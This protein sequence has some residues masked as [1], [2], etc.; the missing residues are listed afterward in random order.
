[1]PTAR[2]TVRY[3]PHRAAQAAPA[4]RR[5]GD[6]VG[7]AARMAT[8][9]VAV[10]AANSADHWYVTAGAAQAAQTKAAKG[11]PRPYTPLRPT[12]AGNT[13]LIG[14]RPRKYDVDPGRRTP[15]PRKQTGMRYVPP[16]AVARP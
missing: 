15:R 4:I 13:G 5:P 16:R 9:R 10:A 12:T 14:P 6:A 11:L 7:R 2:R 1:M 3:F 8:N